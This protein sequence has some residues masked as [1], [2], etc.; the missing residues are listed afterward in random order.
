MSLTTAE[1]DV[2]E[3]L[4]ELCG[5]CA[6]RNFFHHPGCKECLGCICVWEKQMYLTGSSSAMTETRQEDGFPKD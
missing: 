5:V 3:G 2:F 6:T 1:A 4:D